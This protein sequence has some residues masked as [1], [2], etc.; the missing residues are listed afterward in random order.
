MR[1]ILVVDDS[2]SVRESLLMIFKDNFGVVTSGFGEDA[3][4]LIEKGGIDLVILGITHP[5]G[6]KLEFLLRLIEYNADIAILLI[7]EQPTLKEVVDVFD[8]SISDHVIKPFS[9]YEVREKVQGLLSRK[10]ATPPLSEVSH[11]A[12]KIAKYRRIYGSHLLEQQV[13]AMVAKTLDNDAP[14]LIQGENGSGHDLVAKIIHYNGLRKG[15]GFF[16]LN[17]AIL[18][19]ESFVKSLL[20]ISG[21]PSSASFGTLFL[22]GIDRAN[23]GIQMRLMVVMEEGTITTK[24]N[25]EVG[26]NLRI[27]A[28][29]CKDLLEK[30]NQGRFRE[31]LFHQLNVIP[32]RLSP[33]RERREDIPKIAEDIL[34]E[35]SERMKLQRKRLSPDALNEL[36]NYYWPGNLTEL[37]SVI[38]RSAILADTEIISGGEVYFSIE[39]NMVR[40]PPKDEGME[41]LGKERLLDFSFDTLMVNLA[42]EINN[43]LVSIKTFTQLLPERFDDDKFRGEFHQIVE[44]DVNRICSLMEGITGYTQFSKPIFC[45]VDVCSVIEDALRKNRDKLVRSKSIVLKKFEKDLPPVLSDKDQLRYIFDNVFSNAISIAPEGMDLS[46]SAAVSDRDLRG[47]NHLAGLEELDGRTVEITI[48]L[49]YLKMN[50][51]T[52][53]DS[54]P[55]TGLRLFLTQ[56]LVNKNLGLME[57]KA[58]AEGEALIKIKLPAAFN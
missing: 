17:C 28:S 57:I 16:K 38:T 58:I 39:G 40:V 32:I 15:E 22:E 47:M 33:L 1:K 4:S 9:V 5:L 18:I 55:I 45:R 42:H 25:K 48:P 56:R 27:I 24:K 20:A 26:L 7:T 50:S 14:V 51:L 52:L 2:L 11:K 10:K 6:G 43:P 19:E 21:E 54:P 44:E 30:V 31:D 53:P 36:K 35:A 12:G 37:E 13:T 34:N 3:F 49:A 8:Y 41:S 46:L 23:Q 29:T